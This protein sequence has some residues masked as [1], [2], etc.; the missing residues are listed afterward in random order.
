LKI[1][2]PLQLDWEM[3]NISD[4]AVW[5]PGDLS[6]ANEFAEISVTKPSGEEIQMP[7]YAIR[8]DSAFFV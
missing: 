1:G 5:L 3:K 6:I 8:S 4:T 7:P 2:E